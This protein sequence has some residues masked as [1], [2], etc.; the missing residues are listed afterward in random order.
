MAV[1]VGDTFR[2][3]YA[4]SNP[5]WRVMGRAGTGMW[6]CVTQPETIVVGGKSMVVDDYAGVAR[7]FTTSDIERTKAW[8]KRFENVMSDHERFI[9]ELPIGAVV[10]YNDSFKR[11]IRLVRVAG[12]E[13]KRLLPV[14]L[15]GD[16]SKWDLPHRLPDGSIDRGYHAERILKGD[17]MEPNIS[18]IYEGMSATS[19][20]RHEDPRN[21][22]PVSLDV[23][24]MNDGDV[25]LA[26]AIAEYRAVL[27]ALAVPDRNATVDDYRAALSRALTRT[28][29]AVRKLIP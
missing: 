29:D 19:R 28:E 6:R 21:M 18:C 20:A 8:A 15:L 1:K 16:W 12:E 25:R 27:E 13:H 11:W 10:H 7:G 23:P 24:D 5:L 14:A 22:V 3:A 9:S 17:A 26:R 4:D 2:S